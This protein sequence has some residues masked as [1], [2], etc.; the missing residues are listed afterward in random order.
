M[1]KW[2]IYYSWVERADE[3]RFIIKRWYTNKI[4]NWLRRRLFGR[5]LIKPGSYVAVEYCD[6]AIEKGITLDCVKRLRFYHD[7]EWHKEEQYSEAREKQLRSQNNIVVDMAK[8]QMNKFHTSPLDREVV[9]ELQ[10]KRRL[11]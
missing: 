5:D 7:D 6:W 10:I 3:A 8:Y 4:K 11:L 1:N 2:D 9:S